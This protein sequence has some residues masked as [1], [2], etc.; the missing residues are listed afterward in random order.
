MPIDTEWFRDRLASRKLSQRGLAKA[1][2][3]D[4]SAVSLM[5]RGKRRMT[6]DEASQVAVLL[7]STTNEVLAAAGVAVQGGQRVRIMGYV[8]AG[9]RVTLEAE[10][11]HD[12]VEAPPGL[13]VDAVAIQARHG[14]QED[15]WIYYLSETHAAPAQALGQLAVCA[16]R[17]N[18]LLLAHVRRG[19]RGGAFNLAPTG[20]A[21]QTNVALAWAA[22]VLWIRTSPP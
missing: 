2:G 20:S 5:F 15:G 19:Y 7:Q 22:P 12:T 8:Q 13:P 17:D 16:V 21:E 3:V 14:G 1:M 10:G 9:G 4:P 6:V 11:L 18:G